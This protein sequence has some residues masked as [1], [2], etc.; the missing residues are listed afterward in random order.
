MLLLEFGQGS[1]TAHL[2]VNGHLVIDP[3]VLALTG[4]FSGWSE[5]NKRHEGY[6]RSM[7][8]LHWGLNAFM[9]AL[10]IFGIFVKRSPRK[11]VEDMGDGVNWQL[12]G[13]AIMVHSP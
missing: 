7:S 11:R 1:Q 6:S 12:G 2:A 3:L 10:G 9:L 8:R 13:R 4:P 5:S